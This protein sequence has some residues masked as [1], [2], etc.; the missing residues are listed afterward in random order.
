MGAQLKVREEKISFR[1][2]QEHDLK[3]LKKMLL[4][5]QKAAV[6]VLAKLMNSQDEKI[7][8][9]AASKMLDLLKEVTNAIDADDIKRMFLESKNP[10]RTGQLSVD[11]DDTPDVDFTRLQKM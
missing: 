11:D 2:K 4:K 1:R 5:E 6:D 9:Q 7:A 8:M 3:S 10:E